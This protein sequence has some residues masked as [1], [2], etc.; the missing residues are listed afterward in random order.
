ML[1]DLSVSEFVALFNQTLE[2]AYPNVTIIGE[3]ANF[4]ISKNKWLYFDLK[5]DEAI[6]RFFGSVYVMP[7]PL[8]DGMLIK[9]RGAPHLHPQ[10][11]FSITVQSIT[12][13]G[14][15]AIKKAASLLEAKLRAEGLFAPDRKRFLPYPPE[16]IGLITSIES[17]AYTDFVKVISDRWGGLEIELIDV[18]VQGEQAPE[19]IVQAI[20]AFNGLAEPPDVLVVTRGGGSTEDLQVYSAE[21]VTRAVANSRIPT[22]VAIGHERDVSLSELAA[23]Q[24][25]STPSNAAELLVPD[26]TQILNELVSMGNNLSRSVTDILADAKSWIIDQQAS[27]QQLVGQTFK[28]TADNVLLRGRLLAVLDPQT[29][30]KRGYA[31]VR[32]EGT[33]LRKMA[34]LKL[35]DIVEVEMGDGQFHAKV[36]AIER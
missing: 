16:R 35:D 26:R 5:D 32:K 2:F 6:V 7:G 14:E 34:G 36:E 11:G 31:L 12:P 25:A 19:Q 28:N 3:L 24:R 22:L 27:L 33:I 8:E 15:G 29:P 9:V 18:Q 17:A 23:D 30:L 1:P 13:Y 20:T 10:Y 21:S 4:R